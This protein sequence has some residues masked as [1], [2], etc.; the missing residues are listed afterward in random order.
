MSFRSPIRRAI[1]PVKRLGPV[2]CRC[3]RFAN[4][5]FEMSIVRFH[6]GFP[7]CNVMSEFCLKKIRKLTL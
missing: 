3:Y 7:G 4:L 2:F 1:D 6:V 5:L